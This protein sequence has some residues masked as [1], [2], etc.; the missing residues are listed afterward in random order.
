MKIAILTIHKIL[1]YGSALQTY[2]LQNYLENNKEGVI[3]DIINYKFPNSY[4]RKE[5]NKKLN[6]YRITRNRIHRLKEFFSTKERRRRFELFWKENYHL[7]K[8]Y[9]SQNSIKSCSPKGYD[10]YILGSD[11]VWNPNTLCG[12]DVF[13][14]SFLESNSYFFSYASSF[15]VTTI[16]NTPYYDSFKKYL[17]RFKGLGVRENTAADILNKLD[18]KNIQVV[19]DPTFLLN[20][21]DYAKLA[22]KSSISIKGEYILIYML[23]YAFNPFPAIQDVVEKVYQQLH[24]KIVFIGRSFNFIKKDT[25]IYKDIGPYEFL[26]LFMNAK[27]VVTS[28]FHGTAFAIINRKP[29]VSIAPHT[30]DSRI[31]DLLEVLG[32]KA[33]LV[34]NN[35]NN[36]KV[37]F[38]QKYDDSIE[39]NINILITKS[40]KYIINHIQQYKYAQNR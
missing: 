39:N 40:K 3:C 17:P 30:R 34:Y 37:N 6:I 22:N 33:N 16:D 2:A 28:S 10:I 23:N 32:L 31:Q 26:Y 25:A 36:V 24:C 8:Y 14:F 11:Q 38:D 4:H 29:F 19:C 13:L 1:N 15:G 21:N 27:F 35:Q 5:R 18:L 7:T 12:D 9:S 20:K